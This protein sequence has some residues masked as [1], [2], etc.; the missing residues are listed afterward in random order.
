MELYQG[1][2]GSVFVGVAT[3]LLACSSMKENA[4]HL[5]YQEKAQELLGSDLSYY[6]N[7][8]ST[9]VLCLKVKK[10]DDLPQPQSVHY[11]VLSLADLKVLHQA[12]MA[13]GSVAW[14][15]EDNLLV[16]NRKNYPQGPVPEAYVL[17]VIDKSRKKYTN[18]YPSQRE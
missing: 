15:D 5:A 12:H 16:K 10:A 6:F 17:N 8:D 3:L 11:A 13:N 9:R 14:L 1:L 7:N 2:I 18:P 4:G